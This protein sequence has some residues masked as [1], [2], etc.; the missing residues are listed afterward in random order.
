MADSRIVTCG[1]CGETFTTTDSRKK[2]CNKQHADRARNVSTSRLVPAGSITDLKDFRKLT[3]E[4]KQRVLLGEEQFRIVFFDL[5]CTHLKPNVGRILCASL[6]PIG[7]DVHTLHAHERRFMKADV[8]DDAALA[9]AIRDELEKYDIIVGWNSKMFDVKFLNSRNLHAGQRTK[10]AQYHVDGMWSWRSKASAWS[11]LDP[12]QKFIAP[13]GTSKSEVVW[14]Q[15]MRA[16]GWDKKM[17]DQAMA[18]IVNHC[19]RDVFVLEEVYEM[20]VRNG[21]VRSLRKDGGVL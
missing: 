19:E 8:F 7:E 11:G 20:L 17:R 21:V 13:D 3:D 16:I 12:V 14:P 1:Y 2:Y 9:L 6:K 10:I 4:A 5:E 15:W 18:D